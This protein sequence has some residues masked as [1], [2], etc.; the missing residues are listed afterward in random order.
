MNKIELIDETDVNLFTANANNIIKEAQKK[1]LTLIEPYE[2][3]IQDINNIVIKYIKDNKRKIYGGFALNYLLKSKD[4][5]A[6]IYEED[7]IP[8]IDFYS[9][10]PLKDLVTLCNIIYQKGYMNVVG[11]EAFHKETYTLKV[12]DLA[13]ADISYVPRNIY[14]KMP[15]REIE[16]FNVI[17]PEFMVIDYYRMLTDLILTNWRLEKTVTRLYLLQKY[18]PLP[19]I[20]SQIEI[21][22]LTEDVEEINKLMDEILA[23][24]ENNNDLIVIGFYAYDQFLYESKISANNKRFK[25]LEIPYYEVI[26]TNYKN[27]AFSLID[28]LKKISNDKIHVK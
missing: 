26:T 14:N 13:F 19:Y 23:F 22:E 10:E 5:T 25:Y 20:K 8:D 4:P 24:L 16:G 15:F 28:R 12:K 27:T 18:Y 1:R 6:A 21:P 2:A 17:G 3:E 7:D 9:P 11:R